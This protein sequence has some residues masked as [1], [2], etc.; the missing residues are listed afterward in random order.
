LPEIG[1]IGR[2]SHVQ[3]GIRP[4]GHTHTNGQAQS[5]DKFHPAAVKIQGGSQ[6]N[7]RRED[8]AAKFQ[9]KTKCFMSVLFLSV[10]DS[11]LSL[12]TYANKKIVIP[13]RTQ[14][15]M[16]VITPAILEKTPM[17]MSQ[18]PHAKP[19][20]LLWNGKKTK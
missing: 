10:A 9:N 5:Q 17:K 6:S 19:A 20:L 13:P 18:K 16:L 11:I 2:C 7:S 8:I 12:F 15:G 14:S 3:E 4:D 1:R